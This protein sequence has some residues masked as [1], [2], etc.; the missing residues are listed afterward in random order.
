MNKLAKT[1]ENK[2]RYARETKQKQRQKGKQKYG[3]I[4]TDNSRKH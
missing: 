2:R 1:R 4:I 3:R